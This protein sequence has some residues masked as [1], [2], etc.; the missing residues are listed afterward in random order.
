MWRVFW[1]ELANLQSD[2]AF[3]WPVWHLVFIALADSLEYWVQPIIAFF[4]ISSF[5][6][7]I[8]HLSAARFSRLVCR[9]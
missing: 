3:V 7:E 5:G 8:A 9:F 2:W 4:G 1:P 6:T